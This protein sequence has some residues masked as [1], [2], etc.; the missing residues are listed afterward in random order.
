MRETIALI[1]AVILLASPVMAQTGEQSNESKRSAGLKKVWIGVG[2][3]A[4][5]T[6]LAAKASDTSSATSSLSTS[7]LATGLVIAGAGGFLVWKGLRERKAA[8]YS[9]TFGFS[10][11]T[12]S[13]GVFVRRSW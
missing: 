12:Q 9:T 4:L 5:G 7:Q 8:R 13:S 1:L 2:A 10:A 11:S 6:V 3:L